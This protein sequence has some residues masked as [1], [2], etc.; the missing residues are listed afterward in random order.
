MTSSKNVRELVK[1]GLE[2][3]INKRISVSVFDRFGKNN[4]MFLNQFD[5]TKKSLKDFETQKLRNSLEDSLITV[6]REIQDKKKEL[7][8]L[9]RFNKKK[10]SEAENLWDQAEELKEELQSE[11]DFLQLQTQSK[12][13]NVSDA[14]LYGEEQDKEATIIQW[15]LDALP[16]VPTN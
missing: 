3:E 1:Q 2:V 15:K 4:F 6:E 8:L 14:E 13:N 7:V 10:I 11:L 9:S 12:I 5:K 16:K